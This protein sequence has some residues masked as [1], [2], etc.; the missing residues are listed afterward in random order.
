MSNGTAAMALE[1]GAY[2]LDHLDGRSVPVHGGQTLVMGE[3]PVLIRFRPSTA[4]HVGR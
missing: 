4:P 1:P 2:R 3:R